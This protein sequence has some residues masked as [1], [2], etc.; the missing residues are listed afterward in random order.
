MTTNLRSALMLGAAALLAPSIAAAQEERAEDEGVFSIV[1]ENDSL[2]SGAD[3]NYTSGIKLAYV[4]PTRDIPG[5]LSGGAS[6]VEDITGARP[7]FWGA[8]LGQSI[9]TPEDIS[10][11]PAP[12]DQHPYAGWLYAQILLGTVENRP[13][14]LFPRYADLY[15]FEFGMVGPSAQGRQAQRG[16]H[17][18]LGAPD[19]QGWDS[20]LHDEFAFALS[21]ERR[22]S[23]FRY[24]TDYVPGGMEIVLSPSI[25]ATVGTL[26]TEARVGLAAQIG[27]QIINSYEVGPPRVRP[28]LSGAGYFD[29]HDFSW[30]LFA[31]VQGRAV[32]RNLFLDGNT[33]VDSPSV[34]RIPLVVDGQLGFTLQFGDARLAYTYVVRTDEFETQSAPQDFGT[35]ALQ[36]RF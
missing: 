16:I 18:L 31:G 10:A 7:A 12:P 3:R 36:F 5:W 24:F 13:D 6:L 8:A 26:R 17:Q 27:Y 35:V 4:R 9:F 21:Y 11:D 22:W 28:S 1:L 29:R 15:E 14:G 20:Q 30:S 23:S 33:F 34:E 2:S 25:G 19:P 32:A